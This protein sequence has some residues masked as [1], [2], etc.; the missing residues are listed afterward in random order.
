MAR[1][2]GEALWDW[3]GGLIWLCAA[4]G[5]GA[6]IAAAVAGCGHA[7]LIRGEGGP[8]F[9]LESTEVAGLSAGLR[10]QFDPRSILNRGM[11][12]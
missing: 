1:T 7:T 9:P 6:D 11:M 2:E 10:A 5:R 4:P 3:A 12:G 8:V